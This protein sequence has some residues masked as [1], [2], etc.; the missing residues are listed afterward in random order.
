MTHVQHAA[1]LHPATVTKVSREQPKRRRRYYGH[2]EPTHTT[3]V[4]VNPLVWEAALQA[5]RGHPG[6]IEVID[7]T[8]VQVHNDTEWRRRLARP[9]SHTKGGI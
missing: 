5:A 3:T 7:A 8:H 4:V 9:P 2:R 6:R 1:S